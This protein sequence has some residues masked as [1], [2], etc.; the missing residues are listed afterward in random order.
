MF[1]PISSSHSSAWER[2][3]RGNQPWAIR[4][5]NRPTAKQ[6]LLPKRIASVPSEPGSNPETKERSADTWVNSVIKACNWG[7]PQSQDLDE[8][9]KASLG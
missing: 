6:G 8:R 2:T 9:E 1:Q 5:P 7:M 3:T 4:D